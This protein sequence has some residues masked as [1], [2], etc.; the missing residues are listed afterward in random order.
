M[1]KVIKNYGVSHFGI[2]GKDC[3]PNRDSYSSHALA[4]YGK[5]L[6]DLTVAMEK[7]E[8][9][10]AI[11]GGQP[12]NMSNEEWLA[13]TNANQAIY[14][15]EWAGSRKRAPVE[16]AATQFH[17]AR[18]YYMQMPAD[19]RDKFEAQDPTIQTRAKKLETLFDEQFGFVI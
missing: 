2:M 5:Y 19:V 14:Q 17:S 9:Q 6:A 8:R 11:F 4:R 7:F 13:I 3:E 12:A 16:Q 10:S 18:F 15:T 1:T